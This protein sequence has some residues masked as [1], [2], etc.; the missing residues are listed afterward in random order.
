MYTNEEYCEMV[1]MYGQY[2]RNKREAAKL[3]AI[4]FPSRKHPSYCTIASVV[5]RLYKTGSCHKRIPL[6]RVT[7]S[8]LRIHAEDVLGYALA[9]P[10]SSIRDISKGCSY[11]NLMVWNILRI[12]L[13][14]IPSAGTN[15]RRLGASV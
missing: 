6:S 12:S 4:K 13:S 5:Q 9:D 10:E 7:H 2:H 15:T 3:Y 8:S 11:S 1:L 14:S